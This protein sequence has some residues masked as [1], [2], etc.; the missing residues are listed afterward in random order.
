LYFFT[1][2]FYFFC[3]NIHIFSIFIEIF[4]ILLIN[5]VAKIVNILQEFDEIPVE[6]YA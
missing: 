3:K 1:K 4:Y 2:I 5:S 6:M